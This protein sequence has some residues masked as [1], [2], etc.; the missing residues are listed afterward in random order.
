MMKHALNI[1]LYSLKKIWKCLHYNS[2]VQF[3]II[4]EFSYGFT[5]PFCVIHSLVLLK[6]NLNKYADKNT[7][8]SG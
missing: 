5:G 3:I 8:F 1:D 6:A 2:A 7:N 4:Y